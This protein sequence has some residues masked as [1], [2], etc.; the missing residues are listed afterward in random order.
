MADE[1]RRGRRRF[2]ADL[3]FLGG[4]LTA[5]AMAARLMSPEPPEVLPSGSPTPLAKSVSLPTAEPGIAGGLEAPV[6]SPSPRSRDPFKPPHP[7][8]LKQHRTDELPGN[9]QIPT[10]CP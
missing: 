6:A 10:R 2:L 5:A 4:G 9:Y 7:D 1:D 8:Q 3:L